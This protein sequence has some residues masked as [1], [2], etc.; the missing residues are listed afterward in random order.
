SLPENAKPG[1]LVTTLMATDAD[2]EPAFRLMDFSIEAG[3]PEGIFD[4]AWE[5]DSDRVQLRLHKNLSYEA[6][7]HHEVVV[8]VQNVEELLGPGPGPGSTATVTVLVERVVPPLK[9]DQE[10]Y[11]ASVPVST[12]AGSFLLTIQPSNPMRSLSSIQ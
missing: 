4:L 7:P 1:T 3:D 2:L 12:P 10:S 6:A 9:L 8:V 11:E 5:P